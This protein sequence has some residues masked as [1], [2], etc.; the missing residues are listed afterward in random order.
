MRRREPRAEVPIV[1][2]RYDGGVRAILFF[3]ALSLAIGQP[4]ADQPAQASQQLGMRN[5]YFL[6]LPGGLEHFV[7]NHLVKRG[8][9]TVVTDPQLADAVFTD[10][11]GKGFEKRLLELYPP[12][13]PPKP[14]PND[15]KDKDAKKDDDPSSPM[16]VKSAPQERFSS[17]GRGKGTIF[18]VDRK[19]N[20][21]LWS[22]YVR[23]K[24]GTADDLD[25]AA[26]TIVDRIQD[27]LKG[28][29]R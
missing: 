24:S 10:T 12:P 28:A 4:Q 20:L 11:L 17:F 14:E 16:D 21:V 9:L 29:S 1:A 22:A 8:L 6:P 13:P 26:K 18:L 25:K 5:V 27:K 23:P 2:T 3:F 7:A 15:E 19:T